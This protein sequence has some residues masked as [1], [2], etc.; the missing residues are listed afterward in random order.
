MGRN[1]RG[2]TAQESRGAVLPVLH[3][4]DDLMK[5]FLKYAVELSESAQGSDVQLPGL[6]YW[7]TTYQLWILAS[8]FWIFRGN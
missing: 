8:P 2:I 1:R 7:Y 4:T 6:K 5:S 3:P